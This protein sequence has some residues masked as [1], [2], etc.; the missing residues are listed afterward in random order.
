MK[1][2]YCFF[3]NRSYENNKAQLRVSLNLKQWW[4]KFVIVNH[5]GKKVERISTDTCIFLK[6]FAAVSYL[7]WW[8]CVKFRMCDLIGLT[9]EAIFSSVN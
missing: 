9:T 3:K 4:K 5:N 1:L 2:F 8:K 7:I 6:L